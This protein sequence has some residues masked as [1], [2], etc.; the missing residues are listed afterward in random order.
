IAEVLFGSYNPAGRLPVTFYKSANDLPSFDDY[1]MAGRTYRFFNGTPLYPFGY[2]LSYTTFSYKN[3]RTNTE[4]V[5]KDGAVT[6]S[7]DVTNTGSR[8]GDEVVQV[9]VRHEGSVVERPKQDLRGYS[10]VSLRP[11]ETKTVSMRVDVKSL[12]YWDAARH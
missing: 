10:R 9:Y 7:V 8:L 2:G 6:V 3:L 5:P 12:A 1:R 11:G 4:S